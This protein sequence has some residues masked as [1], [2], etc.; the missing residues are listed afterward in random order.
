MEF[1]TGGSIVSE[2][3]QRR[4]GHVNE[5]ARVVFWVDIFL[6]GILGLSV[7]LV[8]PRA[9]ARLSVSSELKQGHLIYRATPGPQTDSQSVNSGARL[10]EASLNEK[11]TISAVPRHAPAM[12]T[13]LRSLTSI[14][15]IPIVGRIH[16]GGCLLLL[17]Y[18]G[19]LLFAALYKTSLFTNPVRAGYVVVSQIPVVFLFATKNNLI[20]MLLGVGYDHVNYIHRFSGRLLVLAGNVHAIGYIYKW[21]MEGKFTETIQEPKFVWGLVALVCLDILFFFSLAIWRQKA[22]NVFLASHIVG[23]VLLLVAACLHMSASIPYVAAGAGLYVFDFLLRL[24][25]TRVC[26]ARIQRLPELCMTRVQISRLNAGWRA[27]QHV[28]VRVLSFQMGWYGWSEVH[29]FTIASASDASSQEGLI[30][31][32]KNTGRWTQR[33]YDMAH[34]DRRW[35]YGGNTVR[36]MLE[37]PYGGPGNTINA[38]FSGAL[39]AVGGGGISYALSAVQ[40]LVQR[41]AERT[42]S[43]TV[44]DLLWA[45]HHPDCLTPMVPAF[46]QLLLQSASTMTTLQISVFYTRAETI[47]HAI[48]LLDLPSGLTLNSGRPHLSARLADLVERTYASPHLPGCGE[49]HRGVFMGVCGPV[50]L[51]ECARKAIDD[52]DSGIQKAVGGVE[53]HEE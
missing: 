19:V 11:D 37:G 31:L 46:T 32:C 42:S 1:A 6:L 4:A 30:I 39:F 45:V 3:P 21:T 15:R 29:P 23:F 51:G 20:S 14:L 40:E 47:K 38:S 53:L 49:K 26:T 25:K 17:A 50:E 22:Y 5:N 35:E 9:L 18:F 27:G 2:N 28:R 34:E 33:L 44:L 16:L 13:P 10:F 12:T 48:P 8:L 36:V 52:V 24:L 7:L 41:A 43:V